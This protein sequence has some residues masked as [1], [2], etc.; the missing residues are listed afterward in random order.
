MSDFEMIQGQAAGSTRSQVAVMPSVPQTTHRPQMLC[1]RRGGM[2]AVSS[3]NYLVRDLYQQ[4]PSLGHGTCMT[5]VPTH[6]PWFRSWWR[7]LLPRA[8]HSLLLLLSFCSSSKSHCPKGVWQS[9]WG[10][11]VRKQEQTRRDGQGVCPQELFS[12][13]WAKVLIVPV[14]LN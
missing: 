7:D 10:S 13:Y 4:L 14:D 3:L 6:A 8:S 12:Q 9:R 5:R 1:P 11:L 2:P